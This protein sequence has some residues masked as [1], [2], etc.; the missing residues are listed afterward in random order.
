MRFFER[1]GPDRAGARPDRIPG[2][3]PILNQ[4]SRKLEDSVRTLPLAL[5]LP[6]LTLTLALALTPHQ[7]ST[8]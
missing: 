2:S 5:T 1:A 7:H 3:K 6:A 8:K 4:R